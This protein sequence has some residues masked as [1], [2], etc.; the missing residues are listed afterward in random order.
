M[1]DYD[2]LNELVPKTQELHRL[3]FD[4]GYEQGRTDTLN[5]Q[6]CKDVVSRKAVDELSKSLVHVTRDKADFLCKFW[7]GL[8]KLSSVMLQPCDDCISRS[9]VKKYLSAP[10]ANG[11]RVIYESDLDLLPSVT[12][13]KETCE[14]AVNRQAVI[15]LLSYD[16]ANRPAHK[17]VESI[18]N[19][20]SVTPKKET[21]HWIDISISGKIDGH[22]T[23]A[24]ICSKCGA[25]SVFLMIDGKIING[26]L[27]P[28]CGAE[29]VEPQKSEVQ[30][31]T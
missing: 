9:D 22:I 4:K 20:P 15:K 10:D 31:D 13:K 14:D 12:P 8:Q 7:E 28:N 25:T 11:D 1:K 24:Y 18:K 16:W 3:I 6:S 19:L 23:E 5:Q 27:C 2:V 26:D 30:N 29:M 17:A 21:G